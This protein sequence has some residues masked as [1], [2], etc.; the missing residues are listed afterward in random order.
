MKLFKKI[1]KTVKKFA[2]KIKSIV[3]NKET[4]AKVTDVV[5]AVAGSGTSIVV[6]IVLKPFIRTAGLK[7]YQESMAYVGLFFMSSALSRAIKR[8]VRAYYN[9]LLSLFDLQE[10]AIQEVG[11]AA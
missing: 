8:E 7:S 1:T 10:Y 3:R 4:M 2:N 9:D 11:V 6:A 5:G